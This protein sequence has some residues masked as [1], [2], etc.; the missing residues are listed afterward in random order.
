[1]PKADASTLFLCSRTS[2]KGQ[3]N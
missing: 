1:M 3:N 2:S